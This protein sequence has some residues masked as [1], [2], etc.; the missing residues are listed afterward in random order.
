ML[1]MDDV[2][3]ADFLRVGGLL[4]VA[5]TATDGG[6]IDDDSDDIWPSKT[7][8]EI[9]ALIKQRNKRG[10][11]T[12][13]LNGDVSDYAGQ[14]EADGGLA[15]EIL[16]YCNDLGIIYKLM[17]ESGLMRSKY[18]ESRPVDKKY[19]LPQTYLGYTI[20]RVYEKLGGDDR[21][22][23][24]YDQSQKK[25]SKAIENAAAKS[26]TERAGLYLVDG[27]AGIVGPKGKI[28]NN[29]HTAAELLARDN[30]LIG[31]VFFDLFALMPIASSVFDSAIGGSGG[32]LGRVLTDRDYRH[33]EKWLF[34]NWGVVLRPGEIK[35]VVLGWADRYARNPVVERLDEFAAAWEGESRVGELFVRYFGA[36]PETD[37]EA[38]YLSEIGTR[39]LVGVVARAEVPGAKVDTMVVLESAQG[40]K[41]SSGVTALTAALGYRAFLEGFTLEKL[42]KD[43]K[44]RLRGRVI[45]ECAELDGMTKH[46]AGTLKNFLSTRTDSYRDPYG[47][48]TQD[49]PRTIVLVGTTNETGYLRDPTG[50]RRY[51]PVKV[52]RVNLKAIER[53][54]PQ[55][56][57]EAVRLYRAGVRWWIN[58][59]GEEDK[60]LREIQRRE[61]TKRLAPDTWVEVIEE[62]NEKLIQGLVRHPRWPDAV[63]L[64][65]AQYRLV[66]L[67]SAALDDGIKTRRTVPEEIRFRTALA[68][69]GW[70]HNGSDK[71]GG[72]RLLA[73]AKAAARERTR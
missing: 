3:L 63:A 11:L 60:R 50:N 48:A 32:E 57:G 45:G 8:A 29:V 18:D 69:A 58:E 71:H 16:Y 20:S 26:L 54:A 39:F 23:Y 15:A 27:L 12:K 59:T 68:R 72:W 53:D 61:A 25:A 46:E 14:S 31:A 38:D 55:L 33:V 56:W 36:K 70:V 34:D 40:H 10:K 2:A 49:W 24:W 73:D 41:K 52:G 4:E 65:D 22:S 28:A 21:P 44:L 37:E 9:R 42:D 64:P 30:R 67:M 6:G 7:V 1:P 47:L 66:D 35:R 62:F 43:A 19:G 17:Q 13:L 5:S 51:W